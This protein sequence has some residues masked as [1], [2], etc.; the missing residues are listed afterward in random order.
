M[1]Y[2]TISL[3]HI[4]VF[5]FNRE[6]KVKREAAIK[7]T[8]IDTVAGLVSTNVL[9][10]LAQEKVISTRDSAFPYLALLFCW[11]YLSMLCLTGPCRVHPV[12]AGAGGRGGGRTED[13]GGDG[14]RPPTER[15]SQLS[16]QALNFFYIH[17]HHVQI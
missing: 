8:T 1:M 2:S 6:A 14:S 12:F 9:S 13:A 3:Y 17:S 10:S 11:P 4:N 15:G 7:E 5:S 16:D